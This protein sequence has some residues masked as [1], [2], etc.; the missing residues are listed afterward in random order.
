MNT[1]RVPHVGLAGELLDLLDQLLARG[2]GGVGLAG[3][4]ELHR[5]VGVGEQRDQALGLRQ[6]QRRPLVRRE[7]PGE[8]D[9]ERVGVEHAAAEPAAHERAP[10]R[11]ARPPGCPTPRP[12]R[13]RARADQRSVGAVD[14]VVAEG[15]AEH[16][17]DTRRRPAAAVDAVGDRPDRHLGDGEVRPQLVEHLAA[18]GPVQRRRRRSTA[19][20]GAA[21]SRAML[22]GVGSSAALRGGGRGRTARR[23]TRRTR[24]RTT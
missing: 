18:G 17:V 13:G 21:P 15:A 11:A 12:G 23:S 9:G 4:H 20:P 24:R 8:P 14:P 6:Q 2:V 16:L 10:A 7:P 19:P 5:T 1:N 22:N 3:E